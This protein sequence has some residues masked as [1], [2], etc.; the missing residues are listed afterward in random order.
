MK[1][2]VKQQNAGGNKCNE[3]SKDK[4]SQGETSETG[5]CG[6]YRRDGQIYNR[7]GKTELPLRKKGTREIREGCKRRGGRLKCNKGVCDRCNKE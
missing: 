1:K 4:N 3:G 2:G 5:K 6:V 7:E